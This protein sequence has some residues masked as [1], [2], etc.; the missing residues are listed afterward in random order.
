MSAGRQTLLV[1]TYLSNPAD[2]LATAARGRNAAFVL[3]LT[4]MSA[5]VWLVLSTGLRFRSRTR[6]KFLAAFSTALAM[7]AVAAGALYLGGLAAEPAFQLEWSLGMYAHP[8]L[9]TY[10]SIVFLATVAVVFGVRRFRV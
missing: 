3:A 7:L 4:V 9:F 1:Q 8:P 6:Y 5:A 2:V 10:G